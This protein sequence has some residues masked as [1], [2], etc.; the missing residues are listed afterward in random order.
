MSGRDETA[1]ALPVARQLVARETGEA[2]SSE[3]VAAGAA[4]A[5]EKLSRRLAPLVGDA[6]SHSLFARSLTL[7]RAR[8]PWLEAVALTLPNASWTPLRVCF[9][10]QPVATA[11]EASVFL[12]ATFIGLL[13]KFIGPGL[14]A[15]LLREV[16][17]DVQPVSPS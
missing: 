5:C 14:T 7:A 16:W 1:S 9:E 13:E 3:S 12:L 17:P 2:P 4:R 8:F 10:R 6:G 15:R 11:V